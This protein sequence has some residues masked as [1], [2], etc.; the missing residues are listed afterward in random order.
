MTGQRGQL[1][2]DA[3]PS[4]RGEGVECLR[5]PNEGF[6]GD[7]RVREYAYSATGRYLGSVRQRRRLQRID[8]TSIRV[9]QDC[10]PDATLDGTPMARFR[11]HHEFTVEID[12][13]IRHYRGPAVL[14]TGVSFG[15]GVMLGRG[16]WPVFGHGF[17]SFSVMAEPTRQITGGTFYRAAHLVANIVGVASPAVEAPPTLAGLEWPG[18]VGRRWIGVRSAV[19][20]DGV[21]R[22]ER[23]AERTYGDTSWSDDDDAVQLEPAG[24]AMRVTGAIGGFAIRFGPMLELEGVLADG[25]NVHERHILDAAQG[26]LICIRRVTRSEALFAVEVTRLRCE[27]AR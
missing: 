15:D 6:L 23:R 9:I 21:V 10:E 25:S 3:Q 17:R 11:G 26:R 20:A 2:S 4:P 27:G 8:E 24:G 14:G 19:S 1:G 12:G 22:S 13:R 18:E 5:L 7:W 16:V